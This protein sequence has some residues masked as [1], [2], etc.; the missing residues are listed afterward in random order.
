MFVKFDGMFVNLNKFECFKFEIQEDNGVFYLIFEIYKK[1]ID[2]EPVITFISR[3]RLSDWK[4]ADRCIFCIEELFAEK[5]E[6]SK[7]CDVELLIETQM[8]MS[9]FRVNF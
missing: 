1:S 2:Q 5:M 4:S 9:S 8:K 7:F 3:E 6:S